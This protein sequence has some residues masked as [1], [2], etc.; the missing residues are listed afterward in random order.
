[1]KQNYRWLIV[2]IIAVLL[3]AGAAVG[4]QVGVAAPAAT[5]N[6]TPT[7]DASVRLTT[8][9]GSYNSGLLTVTADGP[10]AAQCTPNRVAYLRFDLSTI[11]SGDTVDSAVLALAAQASLGSLTMAVEGSTNTAWSEDGVGQPALTWNNKPALGSPLA[12]APSAASGSVSF[13]GTGLTDF[14]AANKGNLVTLAITSVGN[15]AT[16]YPC[17]GDPQP[18]QYFYSKENTAQAAAPTLTINSTP[19]A[20]TLSTLHAAGPTVNWPLIVGLG[21]LALVV[22]VGLAVSR[23]RA[24]AR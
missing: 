11:P 22:I 7:D 16:N 9:D 13:S 17:G 5:L 6:L 14:I 23:R 3:L 12:S 15:D 19:T 20:L 4:S 24:A 21:V 8:P 18:Y 10:P 2:G 1:M